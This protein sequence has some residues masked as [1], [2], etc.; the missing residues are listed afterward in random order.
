MFYFLYRL[1]YDTD[2]PLSFLRLFNYLTSRALFASITAMLIV[3]LLGK[4]FIRWLYQ[5]GMRD[6]PRSYGDIN[7]QSKTGTP[8]AGGTLIAISLIIS[9]LLWCNLMSYQILAMLGTVVWFGTMGLVDDILKVRKHDSDGGLSQPVK[10]GLQATFGIIL[11]IF[12]LGG[13]FGH[14]HHMVGKLYVPFV[15]LAVVDLHWGY[16]LFMIFVVLAISN[17]V[18][19]ADGLDGLAI[20]PAGMSILV[21]GIFA[22]I[23]GNV[24]LAKY[25]MY[26]YIP[27]TGELVVFCAAALGACIGFLWYNCYPAQIFMGD[28]GSLTLGGILATLSILLKQEFLFLLAGGI[29]FVEAASVLIQEKIGI[30]MLGRRIFYRA[31]LHHTFQY[32]GMAESKV[33]IRFWIVSAILML[34]ALGSLKIR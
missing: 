28:V 32:M 5:K 21:Y 29:F 13:W 4:P 10:L 1:S 14:N 31:P 19:F 25:F 17:A 26:P 20:V 18:N 15:K 22:Y 7:P 23:I 27:G 34:I 3:L 30:N 8:T 11:S 12:Y 33:T 6:I 2:S 16:S 9:T 24:I